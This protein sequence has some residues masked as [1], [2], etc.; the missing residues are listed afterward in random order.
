MSGAPVGE[1]TNFGDEKR[2]R[3]HAALLDDLFTEAHQALRNARMAVDGVFIVVKTMG[4]DG[5]ANYN[6]TLEGITLCDLNTLVEK[7]NP[8]PPEHP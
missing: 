1:V 7:L 5:V 6:Y 3:R 8:P 4:A 2:R